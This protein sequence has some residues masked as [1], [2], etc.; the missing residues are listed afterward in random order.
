MDAS[1]ASDFSDYHTIVYAHRMQDG[2]M[3]GSLSNYDD[4]AY[5]QAHPSVYVRVSDEVRRYDIFAAHEASVKGVV[6]RLDMEE[7]GLEE[8]F[9]R[10]CLEQSVLETG[11]LPEKNAPVLTLSTCTETGYAKRWVVQALLCDVSVR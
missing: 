8:E 7:S 11:I 3:F 5:W 2:S 1:C 10:T 6:Y 4:A 9:L